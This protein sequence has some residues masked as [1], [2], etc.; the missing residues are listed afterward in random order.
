MS[1]SEKYRRFDAA[2]YLET[3][4]DVARLA[5]PEGKELAYVTQTTLSVDD[6]REIVQALQR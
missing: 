4:D 2:D 3:L 5:P 1:T 6:T